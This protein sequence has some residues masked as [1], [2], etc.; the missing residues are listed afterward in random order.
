MATAAATLPN[1]NALVKLDG[2]DG[3]TVVL[4]D[5]RTGKVLFDPTLEG[6]Q[7]ASR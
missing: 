6:K 3:A 2:A 1:A 7:T 5:G 4:P